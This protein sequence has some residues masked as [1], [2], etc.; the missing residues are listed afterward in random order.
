MAWT[1][2]QSTVFSQMLSAYVQ[3][4]LVAKLFLDYTWVSDAVRNKV[5]TINALTAPTVY[6]YAAGM[7]TISGSEVAYTSQNLTMDQYK[8]ANVSVPDLLIRTSNIVELQPIIGAIGYELAQAQDAAIL[9]AASAVS[10]GIS[11]TNWIGSGS[12][13]AI[14]N[15][16]TESATSGSA[17]DMAVNLGVKLD[18]SHAPKQDRFLIA[19]S[20]FIAQMS[21]D[22]RFTTF[23]PEVKATG[24]F[25]QVA[26]MTVLQSEN[27]PV[28]SSIYSVTAVQ[29][30]CVAGAFGIESVEALRSESDFATK[31]RSLAVYG[32]KVINPTYG[33][34]LF[35]RSAS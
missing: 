26:G 20:W 2:A 29:K 18:E 30:A 11:T 14:N 4:N 21:K 19:P 9:T 17:Y 23:S 33:A 28:G 3:K 6:T 7:G 13:I 10:T 27:V 16:F 15:G 24:V 25:G 5:V 34:V 31:L 32:I 1:S 35:A 22:D 12:S 8:Y